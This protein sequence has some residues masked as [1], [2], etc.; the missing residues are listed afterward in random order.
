MNASQEFTFYGAFFEMLE[1]IWHYMHFPVQ[2][3]IT[4]G[5]IVAV[6]FGLINFLESKKIGG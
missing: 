4:V 1:H 6:T 3:L 5:V 2:A